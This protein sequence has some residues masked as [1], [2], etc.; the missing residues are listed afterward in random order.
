MQILDANACFPLFNQDSEGLWRKQ[1][2][3]FRRTLAHVAAASDQTK[4]LEFLFEQEAPTQTTDC[5]SNTPL[6]VAIKHGAYA[7]ERLI[8]QTIMR[9]KSARRQRADKTTTTKKSGSKVCWKDNNKENSVD[10]PVGGNSVAKLYGMMPLD[11]GVVCG[12]PL[13]SSRR[14]SANGPMSSP[15]VRPSQT[16]DMTYKNKS[17]SKSA[18]PDRRRSSG[19]KTACG[20]RRC[21]VRPPFMAFRSV[22]QEELRPVTVEYIPLPISSA[23]E[24][25]RKARLSS[26]AAIEQRLHQQHDYPK[27][28]C[29]SLNNSTEDLVMDG[30]GLSERELMLQK[31]NEVMKRYTKV[32]GITSRAQSAK[33][34]RTKYHLE[35]ECDASIPKP[36]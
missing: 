4:T 11:A 20:H 35:A 32:T 12:T 25:Q 14:T 18:S 26:A 28:P 3:R 29:S 22:P 13:V 21:A 5:F 6:D 23:A 17:P 7:C 8:R 27:A 2:T 15:Q 33:Y 34:Y 1:C 9:K 31:R 24:N 30:V 16:V 36:R 10:V 19:S